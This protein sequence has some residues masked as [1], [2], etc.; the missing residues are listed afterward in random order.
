M[1]TSVCVRLMAVATV[2]LAPFAAFGQD[3]DTTQSCVDAFVAKNFPGQTPTINIE[4]ESALRVPLSLNARS[5]TLKL[6][7][8]S[9][10]TGRVLATATCTEKRG[11][12]TILP[13]Y[14]AAVTVR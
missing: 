9:R 3:V 10:E 12:V 13:E 7:A 4:K 8:A 1:K 2:A 5:M 6:T 11:V 14:V